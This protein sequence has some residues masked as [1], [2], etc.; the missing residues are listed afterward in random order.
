MGT[1]TVQREVLQK[2][3]DEWFTSAYEGYK[4]PT[5]FDLSW[6]LYSCAL[7]LAAVAD[8]SV[9]DDAKMDLITRIGELYQGSREEEQ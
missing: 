2:L 7:D 3:V 1:D 6:E 8:L 5:K 4:R 9:P